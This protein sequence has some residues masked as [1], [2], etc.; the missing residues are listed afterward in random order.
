MTLMISVGKPHPFGILPKDG[1]CLKAYTPGLIMVL[2]CPYPNV[3]EIGYFEELVSCGIYKTDTFP[4]GLIIWKFGHDWLIETPFNILRDDEV[5][6]FLSDDSNALTRVLIDE[7][8]I[9]RSLNAAGLQWRFIKKLQE[10]WGDESLNWSE[11]ESK[12]GVVV[13]QN[14]TQMLWDKSEKYM[15]KGFEDISNN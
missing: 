12:L 1:A 7:K 15:H 3:Q 5:S 13:Q 9:V 2:V 10:I 11:Y 4:Y 6:S 8:G 14:T